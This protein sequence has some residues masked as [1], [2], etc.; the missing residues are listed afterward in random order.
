MTSSAF[1]LL[2]MRTQPSG[3]AEDVPVW[4]NGVVN[5]FGPKS[6]LLVVDTHDVFIASTLLHSLERTEYH[7]LGFVV[8][9]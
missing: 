1:L 7:H 6:S 5:E 9:F 8:L 4:L 3:K 2:L